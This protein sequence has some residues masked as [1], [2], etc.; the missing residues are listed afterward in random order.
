MLS[1]YLDNVRKLNEYVWDYAFYDLI[2]TKLSD[3]CQVISPSAIFSVLE[4]S[5]YIQG[6]EQFF[7]DLMQI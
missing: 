5:I 2:P 7:Q 3:I 1:G 6:K 4:F